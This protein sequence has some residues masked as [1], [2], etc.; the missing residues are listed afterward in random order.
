MPLKP[1]SLA[2]A[3]VAVGVASIVAAPIAAA[4][5]VWPVAGG[6]CRV[7]RRHHQRPGRSGL[8]RRDQLGQGLQHRTFVTVLRQR[9]LQPRPFARRSAVEDHHRLRRRSVP[10]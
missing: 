2:P 6:R 3:L 7:G 9:D 10:P 8:H 1:E 5:P 4:E